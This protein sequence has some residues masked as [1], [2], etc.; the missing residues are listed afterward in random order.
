MPARDSLMLQAI[1]KKDLRRGD[2]LERWLDGFEQSQRGINQSEEIPALANP[3][4]LFQPLSGP[5]GGAGTGYQPGALAEY[6]RRT[7]DQALAFYVEAG[8]TPVITAAAED[9]PEEPLRRE[10]LPSPYGFLLVPNGIAQIDVRGRV[11]VCTVIV[12]AVRAGGVDIWLLADKDDER[13]QIN[14]L[15]AQR[16]GSL[17]DVPKL[18]P[19]E[20]I[21]IE[22]GGKVP[23]SVGSRKVLPPEMTAQLQVNRVGERGESV[24]WSWPEGIDMDEWLIGANEP[25]PDPVSKWLLTTWRLM[26]QTLTDVREESVDRRVLR[27]ARKI[28]LR[29]ET[30]TVIT[31]RRIKGR[32]GVGDAQIEW[33]HRFWRR[34]HYRNVWCG[35]GDD[36]YQRAV[37]IAPVVVNKDREDLPFLDRE[38]VYSL[39]R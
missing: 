13:D 17:L 1:F 38:H 8:M 30:V 31:L 20:Y 32:E 28:R 16:Y 4:G 21:R 22:F 36:R 7:I 23:L 29:N 27:I 34:G 24:A 11:L 10:D 18:T 3:T 25:I 37:W 15:M 33:S 12:W 14:M 19:A 39:S 9:L 6:F 2:T 26:Q 35:S 5:R